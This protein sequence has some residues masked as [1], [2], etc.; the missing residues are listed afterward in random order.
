MI[1]I[2]FWRGVF[3]KYANVSAIYIHGVY[4]GEVLDNIYDDILEKM[5]AI[6]KYYNSK[7][8][9]NGT[10]KELTFGDMNSFVIEENI[11]SQ[12]YNVIISYHSRY[13]KSSSG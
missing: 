7:V 5:T 10:E 4:C 1:V 12:W 6:K 8:L 2:T 9:S 11:S 13:E 3:Y